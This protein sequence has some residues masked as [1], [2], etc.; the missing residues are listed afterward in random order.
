[1]LRPKHMNV[2][3]LELEGRARKRAK[4]ESKPPHVRPLGAGCILAEPHGNVCGGRLELSICI[5]YP[6]RIYAQPCPSLA[7]MWACQQAGFCPMHLLCW[8]SV[9]AMF[10]P[11]LTSQRHRRHCSLDL[12]ASAVLQVRLP[13]CMLTAACQWQCS[14]AQQLNVPQL[15]LHL[16][17]SS[18]RV[19][20]LR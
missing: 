17:Q 14:A 20:W 19:S 5:C 11:T 18:D 2:P 4:I 1:M 16:H 12:T 3:T 10:Y 6:S 9:Q 13:A 8:P 7:C 15:Q